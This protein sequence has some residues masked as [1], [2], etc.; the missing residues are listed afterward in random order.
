M[1]RMS[2]V[3][4]TVLSGAVSLAADPLE[5]M[6]ADL[7]AKIEIYQRLTA[8]EKRVTAIEEGRVDPV[9]VVQQGDPQAPTPH[10]EIQVALA[11]FR[12]IRPEHTFV[13]FGCGDGRVCIAAAQKWGCKAVG[14]EI[15]PDKAQLARQCVDAAGLADRITIIE[16]D[17]RTTEVK[18]DFGYA[19]LPVDVLKDLGPQIEKLQAFI[20]HNHPV[21]GLKLTKNGNDYQRDTRVA[22]VVTQPAP[23]I[24]Q[25]G[26]VWTPPTVSRPLCTNGNCRMC[27]GGY[28]YR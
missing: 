22:T 17:V 9:A 6:K 12:N 21:P 27:Y 18:A 26:W 8:L 13:D 4:L 10:P 2:M 24:Q 19:F 16:G 3:L 11:K 20:S 5:G 23:V 28:V 15:D 7:Q 14:V 25:H 1:L